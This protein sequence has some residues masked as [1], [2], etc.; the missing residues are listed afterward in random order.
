MSIIIDLQFR[1]CL[2]SVLQSQGVLDHALLN[3]R[4]VEPNLALLNWLKKGLHGEMQWMERSSSSRAD[5]RR[6]FP[7]Y[8]SAALVSLSYYHSQSCEASKKNRISLYAQGRDYHKVL[9]K[10]LKHSYRHLKLSYP[11]LSARWYV[12]TGPVS[13]KYL[14]SFTKLGWI[15]KNTNLISSRHGSFFFL[16]VLFLGAVCEDYNDPTDH[17][18]TCVRCLVHCSTEALFEPYKIDARLCLSYQTIEKKS[19]SDENLFGKE[20]NWLYG[21]DDCQTCC[22]YNRFS[23]MSPIEDFLPRKNYDFEYFLGLDEESFKKEFEGSP[24]RRIGY[25]KFMENLFL[26]LKRQGAIPSGA[27]LAKLLKATKSQ[28]VKTQIKALINIE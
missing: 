8:P 3:L 24:I 10:I 17:C 7:Q 27:T 4:Q 11:E 25:E 1:E 20:S 6:A 26:T 2:S 23:K 28:R 13:E 18:G 5:V 22:P 16:G 19:L 14:A 21:C 9:K 12:D 15:G